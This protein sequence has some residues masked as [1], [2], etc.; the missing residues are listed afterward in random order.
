[1]TRPLLAVFALLCLAAC[2]AGPYV[3]IEGALVA[4]PGG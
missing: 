1:M 4:P 3:Q 2:A